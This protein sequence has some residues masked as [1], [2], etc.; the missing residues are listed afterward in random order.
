MPIGYFYAILTL[1][2]SIVIGQKIQSI[3]ALL[4]I[5]RYVL[6]DIKVQNT[7]NEDIKYECL[8]KLKVTAK[9]Q[10]QT[11]KVK[12]A[13]LDVEYY[14]LFKPKE[15]LLDFEK[16]VKVSFIA[17]II[18]REDPNSIPRRL[19]CYQRGGSKT[20]AI[21]YVVYLAK[22]L[23]KIVFLRIRQYISI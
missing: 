4:K 15:D 10:R 11:L 19:R 9:K 18:T 14:Q 7:I 20:I 23:S 6:G 8:R 1:F 12:K 21:K 13:R 2:L 17:I 16:V 5:S 3:K 22:L